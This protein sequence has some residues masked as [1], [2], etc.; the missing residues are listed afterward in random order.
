V[1]SGLFDLKESKDLEI[2]IGC[3]RTNSLLKALG[4]EWKDIDGAAL[5]RMIE[6]LE[7]KNY[8]QR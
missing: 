5:V 1:H 7:S 6:H 8:L 4:F 2:V 3:E